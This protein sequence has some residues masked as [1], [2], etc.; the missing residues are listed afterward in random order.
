MAFIYEYIILDNETIKFRKCM[1]CPQLSY[2]PCGVLKILKYTKL[3]NNNLLIRTNN[4]D[5]IFEPSEIIGE[6]NL[7]N[8]IKDIANLFDYHFISI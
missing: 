3:E 1:H 6:Y 5:I 7:I 4:Y 2:N 8:D